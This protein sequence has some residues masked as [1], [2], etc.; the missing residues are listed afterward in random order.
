MP[1]LAGQVYILTT[2][3][4]SADPADLRL[5]EI[6]IGACAGERLAG[7]HDG[8]VARFYFKEK[9][10]VTCAESEFSLTR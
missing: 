7:R 5:V 4:D 2:G 1:F 3:E 9:Q 8:M 10:Q 6:R